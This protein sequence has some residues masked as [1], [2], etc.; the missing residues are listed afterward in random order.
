MLDIGISEHE[1]LYNG[2]KGWTINDLE[3]VGEKLGDGGIF[4]FFP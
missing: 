1:L 4:T 3:G 2:H